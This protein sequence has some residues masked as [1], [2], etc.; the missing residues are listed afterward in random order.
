MNIFNLFFISGICCLNLGYSNQTYHSVII[1]STC[2]NIRLTDLK[3]YRAILTDEPI[4]CD[5]E[6]IFTTKL[7]IEDGDTEKTANLDL[8]CNVKF[9]DVSIPVELGEVTFSFHMYDYDIIISDDNIISGFYD[10]ELIVSYDNGVS[11]DEYNSIGY[12]ENVD[13][14]D[15]NY[16]FT[17]PIKEEELENYIDIFSYEMLPTFNIKI[18]N[19]Q[20]DLNYLKS[21]TDD[22]FENGYDLGFENGVELDYSEAYESGYAQALKDSGGLMGFLRTMFNTL[23]DFGNIQLIPGVTIWLLMSVPLVFGLIKVLLTIFR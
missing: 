5:L 23:I 6:A 1:E 22:W 10:V 15:I 8:H 2:P 13:I 19:P 14:F 3:T 11:F 20:N 9:D 7:T 16:Q 4:V 17:E 21:I 12:L 18:L